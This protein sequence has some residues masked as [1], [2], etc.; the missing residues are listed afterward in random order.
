MREHPGK[1]TKIRALIV[2]DSAFYR[3]TFTKMLETSDRMEVIG[4][5]PDGTEAIRLVANK[6]PDVIVLDLEM[7]RMDGFT[8]LRW[9]MSNQPT[10]VVMVSAHSKRANVFNT[11]ELGAVDFIGKPT[12]RASLE[13]MKIQR[14]LLEKV[15]LAASIPAAKLRQRARS[16]ETDAET[17]PEPVSRP[18]APGPASAIGL[19]AIGASTGGPPAVQSIV[20]RLPGDFEP[21]VVV[22]QHMPPGFTNLFAERLDTMSKLSV[23]EARNEEAL[24]PGVVYVA[25]GG[26]HLTLKTRE[27][28]VRAVVLPPSKGDRYVPSVDVLM[29]S[30]AE[31]YGPKSL[32]VILTGM[33][34]DGKKGMRSI[35]EK[36]G[37]TLAESEETAVVFGMPKEAIGEGVVDRVLPLYRMTAEILRLSV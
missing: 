19:V 16:A 6:K 37:L 2:D 11:L 27:G 9:V 4:A 36:G 10:P 14:E 22:V 31:V 34:N 26:H 33:G 18:K 20:T 1:R 30:A 21:T 29:H 8:F 12:P 32:G 23:R 5:A 3:Q 7:P 25:P 15:Q 24:A 28:R 17:I 13:V 35:K